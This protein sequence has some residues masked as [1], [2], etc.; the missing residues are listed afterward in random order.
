M[1]VGRQLRLG[2]GVGAEADEPGAQNL[3]VNFRSSFPKTMGV[4]Q[5]GPKSNFFFISL[6]KR[7]LKSRYTI[8]ELING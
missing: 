4:K 1:E 6:L 2:W 8:I 3:M 7:H 5:T